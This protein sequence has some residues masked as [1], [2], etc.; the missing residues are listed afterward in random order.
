M[1]IGRLIFR[2]HAIERMFQRGISQEAV[3][4]ALE[5]GEVIEDYPDD[6]PYPSRLVLGWHETRPLHV[7]AAADKEADETIVVTAYE[8]DPDEWEEGFKKRKQK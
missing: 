2:V 5:T 4:H 1:E 6:F 8:P 7:V 3:R